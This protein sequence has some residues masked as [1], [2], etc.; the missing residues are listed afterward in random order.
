MYAELYAAINGIDLN[1][2]LALLKKTDLDL[3]LRFTQEGG[4]IGNVLCQ[5]AE[6]LPAVRYLRKEKLLAL[7]LPDTKGLTPFITAILFN[8]QS[9]VAYFRKEKIDTFASL[10]HEEAYTGT[11]TVALTK[12]ALTAKD[13]A[14]NIPLLYAAAS[15]NKE[16]FIK[17]L[18]ATPEEAINKNELSKCILRNKH[19]HL[20]P[21]VVPLL[22]VKDWLD[23][24]EEW[25]NITC[26]ATTNNIVAIDIMLGELEFTNFRNRL[27]QIFIETAITQAMEQHA[28]ILS[29]SYQK[30]MQLND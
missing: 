17:F 8:Q 25:L 14:G 3:V 5:H 10:A 28:S 30:K 22:E 21:F 6:L 20:L 15:G 16:V 11:I 19:N 29:K 7:K 26:P 27:K 9:L 2:T 1:T 18:K 13:E 24:A 12:E 23:G 4:P